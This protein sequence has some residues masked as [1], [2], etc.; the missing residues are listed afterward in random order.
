MFGYPENFKFFFSSGEFSPQK[1]IDAASQFENDVEELVRLATDVSLLGIPGGG[2]QFLA[3]ARAWY[4]LSELKPKGV[5]NKLMSL[6]CLPGDHD[7]LISGD[8]ADALARFDLQELLAAFGA[9]VPSLSQYFSE[10]GCYAVGNA[11]TG[12]LERKD[13]SENDREKVICYM[14]GS[15]SAYKLQHR[16]I[17]ALFLDEITKYCA[18]R[19][20]AESGIKINLDLFALICDAFE[21]DCISPELFSG[22]ALEF[23]FEEFCFDNPKKANTKKALRIKE[24]IGDIVKRLFYENEAAESQTEFSYITEGMMKELRADAKSRTTDRQKI[25]ATIYH[26]MQKLKAEDEGANDKSA[27]DREFERTEKFL[28]IM[29]KSGLNL[30]KNTDENNQKDLG[31]E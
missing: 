10:E 14:I 25:Y 9:H 31:L 17:N 26:L 21:A 27:E 1:Y 20:P 16:D 19:E 15:F 8:L 28:N 23:W 2:M 4:V 11:L 30:K 24:R 29:K 3:P 6:L 5:V 22:D 12:V 18:A 13:I 7:E